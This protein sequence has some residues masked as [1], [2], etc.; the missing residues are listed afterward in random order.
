MV[1]DNEAIR[2]AI[3][4]YD[5]A[6]ERYMPGGVVRMRCQFSPP[7]HIGCGPLLVITL[8]ASCMPWH[9]EPSLNRL[10]NA[11]TKPAWV[12]CNMRLTHPR[13]LHQSTQC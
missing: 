1:R 4:R 2:S 8:T 7:A 9:V 10:R 3:Q 11:R 6:L 12:V 5:D 13:R